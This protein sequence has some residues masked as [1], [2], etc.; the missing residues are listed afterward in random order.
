VFDVQGG[1]GGGGATQSTGN[2][3]GQGGDGIDGD[4]QGGGG[5][6]GGYYGGFGGGGDDNGDGGGGGGGGSN[7]DDDLNSVSANL[8][9]D[10]SGNRREIT[11]QYSEPAPTSLSATPTAENEVTVS[12][13]NPFVDQDGFNVYRSDSLGGSTTAD[14]T[15]VAS[16][17]ATSTSYVDTNVEDG[18]KYYY[19]VTATDSDGFG[20]SAIS[21][22]DTAVTPFPAPQ[23]LTA[24]MSV[25]GSQISLSWTVVDDSP[26]GKI[27]VYRSTDGSLGSSVASL[28]DDATSFVDTNVSAGTTYHYTI[29]RA[30]PDATADSEQVSRDPGENAPQNL[31]VDS[32]GP[33]A[34][35]LS[36][37]DVTSDETE[38]DV[39]RREV[40]DD[41][42][43]TTFQTVANA[44]PPGSE[45]HTDDTVSPSRTYEYQVRVSD[46]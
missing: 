2:A 41:G 24:E 14:Y 36:W 40:F 6:G 5:G 7:Y 28:G 42:T 32:A 17:S 11:L 45:S 30:T 4:T 18:E 27:N 23:N 19:R 38:F 8:R 34:V 22:E 13:S 16:V 10:S 25:D 35:S 15:Q 29:R 33:L 37:V 9:G 44:L 39:L 26:D 21:N 12:W 31:S 3:L 46:T 43:K 20:E 1:L